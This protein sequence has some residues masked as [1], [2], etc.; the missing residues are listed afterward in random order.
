MNAEILKALSDWNPWFEGRF[1]DE[2]RGYTRDYNILE[3][4][5]IDE[6]KILEGARRVGKSTLLYQAIEH[7]LAAKHKVL[8]INFDD[9]ELNK[10]PLKTIVQTYQEA[11][12]FDCLFLDEIQH[13][14]D[15][16]HYVRNIYDRKE[17]Q[18]IW[19]TGSNSS[20]IKKEYKTLLSGRNI[21]LHI[22]PLSFKEYLT[23]KHCDYTS[24]ILSTRKEIEIKQH[25]ENYLN[26][27]GFPAI[28]LREVY[29]KELLINYFED[30]IYK[31]IA[32]RY[33]VNTTKLK[34]LGLYLATN[35]T[36]VISYRNVA[37]SLNLHVNTV[38]D[39]LSYFREVFL[40]SELYKF[41][42]SLKQQFG[43]EK[44]VYCLDT[45][46]AAAVSFRFSDDRGRMLENLV[47]NQLKRRGYEVYFHKTKK[48]C[49]FIVKKNLEITQLIQ[50][51]NHLEN[52]ETRHREIQG[53]VDA[54][55]VYREATGLILTADELGEAEVL[56]ESEKHII[57]ILPIWKWLLEQ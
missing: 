39:Y 19:I 57:K 33:S 31:D 7:L 11:G 37:Q 2:L 22:S 54:L 26:F 34:D 48:E 24:K 14:S 12:D 17:M 6:I 20:L 10:Y 18:Q 53:L 15:W 16:V 43:S 49:D 40:F 28:S 21:T 8:Y 32:T 3:Y 51:C 45:G 42:Y 41:D 13:C 38:T 9:A 56:I 1:P 46:L 4:L 30:F 5:K 36:K 35:S 50:V 29:Q 44:K 55:S 47:Y 23:F 27:G 52:S 25:F